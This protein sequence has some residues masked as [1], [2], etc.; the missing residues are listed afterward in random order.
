LC[1]GIMVG[2]GGD[3]LGVD[4]FSEAE[5]GGYPVT[6]GVFIG[7]YEDAVRGVGLAVERAAGGGA[8]GGARALG[9][10]GERW[11]RRAE[12]GLEP[13]RAARGAAGARGA[14]RDAGAAHD[15]AGADRA[16]WRGAPA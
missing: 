6:L 3:E 8:P 10:R 5:D 12:A 7:V 1:R 16:R 15:G 2:R 11:V 13:A 9:G 4:P 14:R